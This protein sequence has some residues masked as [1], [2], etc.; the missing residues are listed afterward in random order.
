[1]SQSFT[2]GRRR[3][4]QAA[5]AAVTMPYFFVKA[6]AQT[7]PKRLVI[8]TWD[9]ALG[10]FYD[11]QWIGPFMKEFDVKVDT[12]PLVG[13]SVQ[14]DRVRAQI[15]AGRPESDFLPLHPHQAIFAQRNN[16]MLKVDWSA[17]PESKN[18]DP[19]FV[20]ENGPRL[21]IWC[22]GLCYNT[23]LVAQPPTK[24]RDLWD[25]RFKGRAA[26]NEAL[27]E[28]TV[29]MVNLTWNGRTTPIGDDVFQKL[30]ELRPNLLTLW[31]NAA[32]AEQ[33]LRQGEI[34]ITPFWNGRVYNLEAQGAP[35]EFVVPEEG[36]FVRTSLYA[37]PRN[38]TNPELMYK[39]LNFIMGAP[40]QVALAEQFFYGSGNRQVQ[41]SSD[42][43]R[44][45]VTGVPANMARARSED[46]AGI[47]DN[48]ADW[49]RAWQ[50]WKTA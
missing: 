4:T 45:I 35:L 40:R 24:W 21:V 16:M 7:D 8:Y 49:T 32:Q 25:P 6:H 20:T 9:G 12:I 1:M 39:Y 43:A 33:L 27:L 44:K 17:M 48:L 23:K 46:F 37:M 10:R 31:N 3:L 18:Y 19:A 42:L 36:M 26:I 47:L 41:V 38:P 14:L 5:A 11:E 2:S 28:Q 15:N 50:R 29:Q 30:T 13:S 22:Y 34:W